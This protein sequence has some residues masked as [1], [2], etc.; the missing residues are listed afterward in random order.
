MPN[1]LQKIRKGGHNQ[2]ALP[3]KAGQGARK[4]MNKEYAQTREAGDKRVFRTPKPRL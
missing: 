2:K 4:E 3:P 1:I